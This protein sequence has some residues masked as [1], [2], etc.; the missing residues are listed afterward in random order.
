MADEGGIVLPD[1]RCQAR[2]RRAC[3]REDLLLPVGKQLLLAL[4][5]ENLLARL[6]GDAHLGHSNVGDLGTAERLLEVG[7][8]KLAAPGEGELPHINHCLDIGGDEVVDEL[9]NRETLVAKGVETA[10]S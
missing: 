5:L 2:G 1:Q 7:P 10:L 6:G 3:G 4:V 9:I 8:D